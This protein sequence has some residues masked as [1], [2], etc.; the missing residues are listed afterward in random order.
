M[1]DHRSFIP[2][3]LDHQASP[4][5]LTGSMEPLKFAQQVAPH[6]RFDR[7]KYLQPLMF[8]SAQI[9]YA[10]VLTPMRVTEQNTIRLLFV[11]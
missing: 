5:P 11:P 1:V 8:F 3:V 10:T 9:A 6:A 4:A 2:N 7:S